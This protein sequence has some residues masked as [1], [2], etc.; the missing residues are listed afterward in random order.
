MPFKNL[1]YKNIRLFGMVICKITSF[2]L[3][4]LILQEILSHT[5]SAVYHQNAEKYTVIFAVVFLY[6]EI[7]TIVGYFW[8]WLWY[9]RWRRSA[10][11][12]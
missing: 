12:E 2:V 4:T 8:A 11:H 9:I 7:C 3:L 5:S 1:A 10:S 6:L